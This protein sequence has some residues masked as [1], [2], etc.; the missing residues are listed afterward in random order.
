MRTIPSHMP[1][2]K[3][4]KKKLRQDRQRHA[5]HLKME[6]QISKLIKSMRRNP[7]TKLLQ[8]VTSKLDKAAKIHLIHSN[9]AARLKSH[10]AKLLIKPKSPTTKPTARTTAKKAP[11]K[12]RV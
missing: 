3:S 6:E 5:R 11:K 8:E 4:A 1:L 9:K 12:K 10:L 7:S 2:I